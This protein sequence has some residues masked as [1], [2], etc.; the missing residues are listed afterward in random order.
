MYTIAYPSAGHKIT[1]CSDDLLILRPCN[2][3]LL[4][5]LPLTDDLLLVVVLPNPWC[6]LALP[7]CNPPTLHMGIEFLIYVYAL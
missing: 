7:L 3:P 1:E 5:E 4:V 2:L 6:A